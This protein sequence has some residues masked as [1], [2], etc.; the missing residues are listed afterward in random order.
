MLP[1]SGSAAGVAKPSENREASTPL[2]Y[3]APRPAPSLRGRPQPGAFEI[4]AEILNKLDI[5]VIMLTDDE[6]IAYANEWACK[7]VGRDLV[8]RPFA[9]L[10]AEDADDVRLTLAAIAAADDWR[11]F[12][13]TPRQAEGEGSNLALRARPLVVHRPPVLP[14]R[15]ILVT[16]DA[17][18][19]A[20]ALALPEP[21]PD[22]AAGDEPDAQ[23]E[24][25]HRVK[26]NLAL[27]MSLVR[28]ARRNVQDEE[29]DQE[30]SAF[31]R[32][33]M[34]IAAMHDVLDAHRETTSLRAD[35]L[36]S[37]VCEGL[38]DALA[39]DGVVITAEL[40]PLEVP[41]ALGSPIALIV[42]ELITNALKHGF[43]AGRRGAVHVVLRL[44]SDERHE[45]TVS[46]DGV[47][48]AAAAGEERR[49][50]HGSG[51]NIVRALVM[52][53]GGTLLPLEQAVG[54]GWALR[55]TV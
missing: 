11:S 20:P 43:P 44:A 36:L 40:E 19:T 22:L 48:A 7:A 13:L 14:Q 39:P 33:L 12:S 50:S 18:A 47:G 26:N 34:S 55:F 27:L 49:G 32:R 8:D 25:I 42:N 9:E 1:V 41:V 6:H 10:W 4:G 16:S 3:D 35:D 30:I 52:Q 28:T 29:A 46:D 2:A 53:L 54:T 38:E 17:F 31:E 23:R 37:R 5:A 45:I 51:S 21:H 24:L 15:H